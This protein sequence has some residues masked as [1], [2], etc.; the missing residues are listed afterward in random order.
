VRTVSIA[1]PPADGAAGR[2]LLPPVPGE[3][4]DPTAPAVPSA[5]TPVR[6]SR[7]PGRPL[8]LLALPRRP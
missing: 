3:T 5:A 1:L 8:D 4:V 7:R 2:P 6:T